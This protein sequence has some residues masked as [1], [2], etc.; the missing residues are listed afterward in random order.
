MESINPN[1]I[2]SLRIA[3]HTLRAI[4]HPLRQRLMITI[5]ANKNAMDVTSIYNKLNLEQSVVSQHLA[6]LRQSNFVTTKRNGKSISYSVDHKQVNKIIN[7]S[8]QFR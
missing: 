7:I 2:A 5:E 4:N 3:A 8:E 1:N 6:I